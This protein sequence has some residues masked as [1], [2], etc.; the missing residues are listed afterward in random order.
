MYDPIVEPAV[1]DTELL[2][3]DGTGIPEDL[4]TFTVASKLTGVVIVL[5]T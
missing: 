3:S 4:G 2:D 1:M 5:L